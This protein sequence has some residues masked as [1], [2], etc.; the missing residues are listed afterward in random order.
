MSMMRSLCPENDVGDRIF[1]WYRF[2]K[3]QR[4]LP[5]QH[6]KM[7]NDRLY[8]MKV[9]GTLLDPLRQFISDKEFVKIYIAGTVGNEYNIETFDVLRQPSE[10]DAYNPSQFPCVVKPTHLSGPVRICF[11][12]DGFPRPELLMDWMGASHYKRVREQNYKH[13][14]IQDHRRRVHIA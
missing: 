12:A 10:V 5:R 7:I 6:R 8:R 1:S 13:L 14:P 4:R 3:Y 11:S 9:E 2:I